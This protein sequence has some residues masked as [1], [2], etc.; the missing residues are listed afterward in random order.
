M[1]KHGS[2]YKFYSREDVVSYF[3]REM[4]GYRWNDNRDGEILT[5]SNY[6]AIT[7]NCEY[8]VTLYK[9]PCNPKGSLLAYASSEGGVI[10]DYYLEI[11]ELNS[12][13]GKIVPSK[14]TKEELEKFFK[15]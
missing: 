13:D 4:S 1:R 5:K 7:R 6:E 3:N 8:P 2:S 10:C 14:N 11:E 15:A 9:V 12:L